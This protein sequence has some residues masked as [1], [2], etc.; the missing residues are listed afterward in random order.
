MISN[1][2][3]IT[4]ESRTKSKVETILLLKNDCFKATSLH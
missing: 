2:E 1:E 3:H 4:H